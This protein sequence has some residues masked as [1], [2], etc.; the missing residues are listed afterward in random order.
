MCEQ[1]CAETETYLEVIPG[2]VLVRAT[3]DGME[4]L[5]GQWGLLQRD[6]PDFIWTVTPWPEPEYPDDMLD[7]NS[8][9]AK[10]A[11][12]EWD[13]WQQD[14]QRFKRFFHVTPEL[15]WSLIEAA[16]ER[17]YDPETSGWFADWFFTYL[18]KWIETHKPFP[19]NLQDSGTY[20]FKN[21]EAFGY[22]KPDY[23]DS[24]SYAE[25]DEY[26]RI[27][28]RWDPEIERWITL[29][30]TVYQE[31]DHETKEWVPCEE[32]PYVGN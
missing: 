16:K 27:E 22:G 31:F 14:V 4:M 3:K 21:Y 10:A 26:V 32:R 7:E 25:E 8:P 19:P 23:N 17:G 15:G 12:D 24:Y 18:G 30:K 13:R 28:K 6:D 2:W 11:F 20:F 1:C 9:E 5:K 29:S